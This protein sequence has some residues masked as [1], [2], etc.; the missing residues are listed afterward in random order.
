MKVASQK[1]QDDIGTSSGPVSADTHS[2]P[3]PT[4]H[5]PG[6]PAEPVPGLVFGF[7]LE[8][9]RVLDEGSEF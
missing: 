6:D 2:I 5:N 3:V 4:A 8:I 7:Q 1:L 9:P